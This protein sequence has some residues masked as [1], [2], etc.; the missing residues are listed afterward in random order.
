M[1]ERLAALLSVR[2]SARLSGDVTVSH[3]DLGRE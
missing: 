2:L 1:A 3:R